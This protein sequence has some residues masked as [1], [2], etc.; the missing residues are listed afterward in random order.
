MRKFLEKF[1]APV[2]I[3]RIIARHEPSYLLYAL[4]Q[5][6]IDAALPLL[7]VY[8]PRLIIERLTGNFPNRVAK[9]QN[10][11]V[12]FFPYTIVWF[13]GYSLL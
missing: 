11:A 10:S 3:I 13:H 9:S 5:M 4:P 12:N 7:Y 1:A 6:I 8:F 2:E